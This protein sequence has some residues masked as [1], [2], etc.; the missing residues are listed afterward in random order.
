M[1]SRRHRTLRDRKAID[2]ISKSTL[3]SKAALKAC[4]PFRARTPVSRNAEKLPFNIGRIPVRQSRAPVLRAA[5]GKSCR[6]AE[7]GGPR[8]LHRPVAGSYKPLKYIDIYEPLGMARSLLICQRVS[9]REAARAKR[10][11]RSSDQHV[12][13]E[14]A[15]TACEVIFR[16]IAGQRSFSRPWS[17]ATRP[18]DARS[19]PAQTAADPSAPSRW[20]DNNS[21][22]T[23]PDNS[24]SRDA[25]SAGQSANTNS[26]NNNQDANAAPLP[27]AGA[28]ATT[29]APSALPRKVRRLEGRRHQIDRNVVIRRRFCC[30]RSRER[31]HLAGRNADRG[32]ER[33]RGSH[34]GPRHIDGGSRR[35]HRSGDVRHLPPRR[36]RSRRRRSR[37]ASRS[38]PRS[39]AAAP[40]QTQTDP[41]AAAGTAIAAAASAVDPTTAAAAAGHDSKD[42][43]P[44]SRERADAPRPEAQ[45]A[46]RRGFRN[47]RGSS[48]V[49]ATAP[50]APKATPPK[51][52]GRD[53]SRDRRHRTSSDT[54]AGQRRSVGNDRA[55]RGRPTSRPR[56]T[57]RPM[58]RTPM[59]PPIPLRLSAAA[60]TPHEHSADAATGHSAT[61]SPDSG[62]QATGAIQPQ[63]AGRG[64]RSRSGGRLTRHGGDQRRR[65]P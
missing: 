27:T 28:G 54:T 4:E 39:I 56:R 14:R 44:A 22:S 23:A 37:R 9:S 20:S 53:T 61:D 17:T 33:D 13:S 18:T 10:H 38:R 1:R 46:D 5:N 45:A 41:N 59:L 51:G 47:H 63:L 3:R 65:C 29:D 2:A 16:P 43:R 25:A 57:A 19:A 32:A 7:K 12:L 6:R 42:Q 60:V 26:V 55:A 40:A 36:W 31:C 24:R 49:A 58:R 64:N 34:S 8:P 30:S 11:V 15:A 35:S 50:V 62:V 52:R 48:R 21:N